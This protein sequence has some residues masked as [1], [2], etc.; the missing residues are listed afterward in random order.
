MKY[1][2]VAKNEETVIAETYCQDGKKIKE[3]I[4]ITIHIEIE[5]K[6]YDSLNNKYDKG[7][8]NRIEKLLK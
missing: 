6:K 4:E 7:L 3:N 2:Y 5:K 1:S 8:A